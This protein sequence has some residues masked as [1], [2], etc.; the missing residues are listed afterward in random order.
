[1]GVMVW[2]ISKSRGSVDLKD[3]PARDVL[4]DALHS[5]SGRLGWV[6][7]YV[8]AENAYFFGVTEAAEPPAPV[9]PS[10]PPALVRRG[11]PTLTG[12]HP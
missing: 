2:T 9:A 6:L 7:H 11:A 12:L 10:E 5:I 1:M 3:E 8:P 4:V